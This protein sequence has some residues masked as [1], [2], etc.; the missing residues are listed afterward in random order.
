MNFQ[1]FV[2]F[3]FSSF[4]LIEF[5]FWSYSSTVL[6]L[7]VSYSSFS[8]WDQSWGTWTWPRTCPSGCGKCHVC[9]L[10]T[11]V[12]PTKP[13]VCRFLL[14]RCRKWG[15]SEQYSK[16]WDSELVS[17]EKWEVGSWYEQ[18]R[19]KKEEA[20]RPGPDQIGGAATGPMFGTVEAATVS[21]SYLNT[22]T[23]RKCQYTPW[24]HC[25][26]T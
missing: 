10:R 7:P 9:K 8:E 13:S 17:S 18:V 5:A 23:T 12:G 1:S 6:L 20:S 3:F 2:V 16:K 26:Q 19:S 21:S 24:K 4:L 22:H 15:S 14:T 25:S 11:M